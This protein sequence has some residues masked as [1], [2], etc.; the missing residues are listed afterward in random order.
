MVTGI[1]VYFLWSSVLLGN[2]RAQFAFP[3]WKGFNH[4][5]GFGSFDWGKA[6]TISCKTGYFGVSCNNKC[7]YPTYGNQCRLRCDCSESLCNHV[8]G[9]PSPATSCRIGYIGKYCET[10]CR[11]PNYG[12]GCQKLCL[13]AEQRCNSSTGCK[14]MKDSNA[15][16]MHRTSQFTLTSTVNRGKDSATIDMLTADS[17]ISNRDSRV[18]TTGG[19]CPAGFNGKDCVKPCR[20]PSYGLGCQYECFCSTDLCNPSSGCQKNSDEHNG[21]TDKHMETTI[22]RTTIS[23]KRVTSHEKLPIAVEYDSE[24]GLSFFAHQTEPQISPNRYIEIK[25]GLS[26]FGVL[27]F[28]LMIGHLYLSFTRCDKGR[29]GRHSVA[30]SNSQLI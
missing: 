14:Q 17:L 7:K 24:K 18:Y 27:L 30:N 22:E 19:G 26:V 12:A 23:L 20:Y 29:S 10:P 9:C 6:R 8:N 16:F 28:V 13:C 21:G 2:I 1:Y 5:Y 4:R 11:Y 3:F 15:V 25:M